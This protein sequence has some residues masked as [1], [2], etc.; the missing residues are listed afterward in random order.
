[1]SREPGTHTRESRAL[2][3]AAL[4]PLSLVLAGTATLL[5]LLL[6]G[7]AVE[8]APQRDAPPGQHLP[9]HGEGRHHRHG[10]LSRDDAVARTVRHCSRRAPAPRPPGDSHTMDHLPSGGALPEGGAPAS[11][12]VDE[13]ALCPDNTLPRFSDRNTRLD[14]AAHFRHTDYSYARGARA[15]PRCYARDWP[16]LLAA[17]VV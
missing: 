15:P 10:A 8:A 9:Q 1:M 7:T 13:T 11:H 17:A 5:L 3:R 14:Q 12:H 2:S 6:A 4:R 16:R